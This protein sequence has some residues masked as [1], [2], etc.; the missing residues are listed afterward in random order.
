MSFTGYRDDSNDLQTQQN[1]HTLDAYQNSVMDFTLSDSDDSG[2]RRSINNS[3]SE[4]SSVT[5]TGY[6]ET[7][8]NRKR[9]KHKQVS[10]SLFCAFKFLNSLA[11]LVTLCLA[12]GYYST[13]KFSSEVTF[14]MFE[15]MLVA[16]PILLFLFTVV[17]FIRSVKTFDRTFKLKPLP[18]SVLEKKHIKKDGQSSSDS[19]S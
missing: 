17:T 1:L 12:F 8:K 7:H 19:S 18:D 5:E 14:Y 2:K 3:S 11:Y 6:G 4:D 9:K 10:V 13:M 15:A 16:R